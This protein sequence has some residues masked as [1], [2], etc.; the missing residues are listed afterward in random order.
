M[1]RYLFVSKNSKK[2]LSFRKYVFSSCDF[3]PFSRNFIY[4]FFSA[5]LSLGAFI[6]YFKHTQQ[7]LSSSYYGNVNIQKA[8]ERQRRNVF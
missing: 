8:E 3:A 7:L 6:L 2:V 1:K 5:G 4:I